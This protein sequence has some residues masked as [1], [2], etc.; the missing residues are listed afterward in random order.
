MIT[1]TIH[2][3]GSILLVRARPGAKRNAFQGEHNRAIRIEVVAA[4]EN[5][6]ANEAIVALL[7]EV[8]DCKRHRIT[9]ISGAT[10]RDKKF[11]IEGM[12][13]QAIKARLIG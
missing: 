8:L 3:R 1:V 10:S 5:G 7:A 9:L 4:P 11:L 6:Q 13:P 2:E 12:T